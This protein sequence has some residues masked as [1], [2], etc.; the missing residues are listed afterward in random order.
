MTRRQ[1]LSALYRRLAIHMSP[2]EAEEHLTYYAEILADRM[3]E[4]MSEE[5]AVAGLE[6][7]E[8]IV[9]RILEDRGKEEKS[10]IPPIYPDLPP[11]SAEGRG[12]AFNSGIPHTRKEMPRWAAAL[13]ASLAVVLVGGLAIAWKSLDLI[14]RGIAIDDD[15]IRIGDS[16]EIGSDGIHVGNSLP[17]LEG[18]SVLESASDKPVTETTSEVLPVEGLDT[19]LEQLL[20]E[21]GEIWYSAS[22][23][24]TEYIVDVQNIREISID[25]LSGSVS[26][27]MDSSAT[28]IAIQ[29]GTN[30]NIASTRMTC[31]V[32]DGELEIDSGSG[33]A[34]SKDLCVILPVD[35]AAT[36]ESL[37]IATTSARVEVYGICEVK[38]MDIETISGSVTIGGED[39]AYCQELS[40]STNSGSVEIY[41][42]LAEELYMSST[43]GEL[44]YTYNGAGNIFCNIE[45]ETVSG[46][47]SLSLPEDLGFTLTVDTVSGSLNSEYPMTRSGEAFVVGSGDC[48][49]EISTV[50]GGIS[51]YPA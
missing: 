42:T 11:R 17:V 35:L 41:C 6:D 33:T 25:W 14:G 29:E 8:T 30:Q 50:S 37:D 18:T 49:I 45:A 1:F 13:I 34:L 7:V 31:T 51:I 47:V 40:V 12:D 23:E 36:L 43:S 4:G 32:E 15:G 2:E 19:G 24:S 10:A 48:E 46:H 9:R 38:E 39:S 3:E 21:D 5:E 16:I 22:P 44:M 28:D 20:T 27:F 26:V